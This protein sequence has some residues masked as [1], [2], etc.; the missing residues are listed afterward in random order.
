MFVARFGG[1]SDSLRE[2]LLRFAVAGL[3]GEE[4]A[5]HQISGDVF[6]MALEEGA[7]MCV[8][9]G[10]VASVHALQ[11]KPL[12]GEGVI[13]RLGKELFKHLAA[14]FLLFLPWGVSGYAG[15]VGG[16]HDYAG[17]KG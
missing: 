16:V 15:T 11:R 4:R 1:S 13:G 5:V 12:T 14:G 17:G 6:G 2:R 8:G 10:E 3:A 9:R 7:K